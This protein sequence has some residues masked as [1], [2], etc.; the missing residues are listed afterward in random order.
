MNKKQRQR[1]LI[2]ATSSEDANIVLWS[3]SM[4]GPYEIFV[5]GPSAENIDLMF[6]PRIA[7][8]Y[9]QRSQWLCSE[10]ESGKLIEQIR[11]IV[12]DNG[13]SIVIPTGFDSLRFLGR[14][15]VSISS[16]VRIV[17][18]PSP[19]QV[20]GLNNKANFFE[21]CQKSGIP[22]PRT[23]L[24]TNLSQINSDL[25]R[26][27]GMPLLT[28]PLAMSGGKGIRRFEDLIALRE[29]L[30][31]RQESECNRLPL[32]LQEFIPG[33]DYE[34]NA[35]A[36]KG[37]VRA[38]TIQRFIEINR[39]NNEPL[40]W[41]QFIENEQVLKMG[42]NITGKIQYSGPINIAFRRDTHDG[43]LKALEVNPRFWASTF[44][45]VI[46]GVNFVEAAI[47]ASFDSH[48]SARP[49]CSGAIWGSPHWLP[50]VL[51]AHPHKPYFEFARKHSF[52][53][54]KYIIFNKFFSSLSKFRQQWEKIMKRV[55]FYVRLVGIPYVIKKFLFKIVSGFK[56][57]EIY[58]FLKD[59]DKQ[60]SS[61]FPLGEEYKIFRMN[62]DDL[63]RLL[64]IIDQDRLTELKDRI[65]REECY[66]VEKNREICS[67]A[68]VTRGE[69]EILHD[70][71]SF[72]IGSEDIYVHDCFTLPAYRGLN[73]LPGLLTH[74]AQEYFKSGYRRIYT[75]IYS[76]NIPSIKAFLKEDFRL[77]RIISGQS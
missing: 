47:R 2:L 57:Y 15:Q 44:Y 34:F 12:A 27:P 37:E 43:E 64:S 31:S 74:V 18:V 3:L 77:Y 33:D 24:L 70:L 25:I 16:F 13:I 58:I 6:D 9:K 75:I 72:P 32:V 68:W 56:Y 62:T 54:V 22:T 42:E 50:Y 11:R 73:L 14:V 20:D 52:M 28:K 7:K 26:Y 17:P 45:S 61:C 59:L 38:W 48:F 5:T 66:A 41:Y 30:S 36:V 51:F 65:K 1:V 35:M 67:Y 10:A 19:E 21:F 69:R 40:R 60:D 39:K 53:Q 8:F 63:P 76:H 46:D 71:I 4:A 23:L 29:Y 55:G 49:R